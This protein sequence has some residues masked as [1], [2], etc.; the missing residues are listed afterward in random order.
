MLIMALPVLSSRRP[1]WAASFMVSSFF[2]L[3][4]SPYSAALEGR[5]LLWL[6][7]LI[8]SPSTNGNEIIPY[9]ASL[10]KWSQTLDNALAN[11]ASLARSPL[12][13]FAP[14]ASPRIAPSLA[15]PS[16]G[17]AMLASALH[18][19]PFP[20]HRL[21]SIAS[22]IPSA[23]FQVMSGLLAFVLI[24]LKITPTNSPSFASLKLSL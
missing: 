18:L 13:S 6:H 24:A 4:Y 3:Y 20:M 11:Q 17:L 5:L 10:A 9:L 21:P 1:Y 7:P 19:A 8:L 14:L 22:I 12:N 16:I 15:F 23:T 2:V